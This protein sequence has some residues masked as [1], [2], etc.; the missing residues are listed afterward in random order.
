MFSFFS[1]IPNAY[2]K[3]LKGF[4]SQWRTQEGEIALVSDKQ[5]AATP[6]P[7]AGAKDETTGTTPADSAQKEEGAKDESGTELLNP[8]DLVL[9]VG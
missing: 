3:R 6:T 7:E 8:E 4:L 9:E 5:S 1:G 2:E